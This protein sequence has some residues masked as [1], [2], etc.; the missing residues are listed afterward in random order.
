MDLCRFQ[1]KECYSTQRA[2][3]LA[4]QKRCFTCLNG[5][6][7]FPQCS[8]AK[9]C[10]KPECD[11][12]NNVLLHGAEKI[13]P[14]SENSNVS[15]KAGTNKSKENTNTSTH[16]AI[17]DVHDIESFYGLLPIATLGVSSDVTSLPTL[18]L[19]DSAS[20]HSW[21]SSSLV[22]RLRLV[23][24]P[25]NLSISGFNSTTVVGTQRVKFTV[26][27]EPNNSD[28][29][30]SLCAFVKDNFPIGSELINI[31][32][33]QDK[34]PQLAP[35]KPTQYTC[36]DVEVII[37]QNYYHAVRP[38]EFIL[39]DDKNSPCSVRLPILW[40]ISG[41]LPPSVRSTSSC[42]KC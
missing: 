15:N 26:S 23:G 21:V 32:N 42:F 39:G 5:N 9:K 18:V 19:C 35:I 7:S 24:E 33:L 41:P 4:E 3:Y 40:V 11:S 36:E 29:V 38:I 13:S 12:T 27:S 14:R 22:N 25:V 6:H 30:F 34:N 1:G 8:R 37:G 10:P 16:A 2:K 20:T 17:S 31:A 28:F